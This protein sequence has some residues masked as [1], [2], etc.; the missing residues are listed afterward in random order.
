MCQH[1]IPFEPTLYTEAGD[2]HEHS[3]FVNVY[4]V[5]N[6]LNLRLISRVRIVSLQIYLAFDHICVLFPTIQKLSSI[7]YMFTFFFRK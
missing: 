1:L 7:I 6:V 2:E 4:F 5:L 3:D